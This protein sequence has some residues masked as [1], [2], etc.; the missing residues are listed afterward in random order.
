M[1]APH[2]QCAL[3]RCSQPFVRTKVIVSRITAD[4]FLEGNSRKV[5]RPKLVCGVG[6]HFAAPWT[7]SFNVSHVHSQI[8]RPS[9]TAPPT[10]HTLPRSMIAVS[11]VNRAAKLSDTPLHMTLMTC[12]VPA[13][14]HLCIRTQVHHRLRTVTVH[15]LWSM[16]PKHRFLTQS[17][18][19]LLLWGLQPHHQHWAT[20]RWTERCSARS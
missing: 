5:E 3:V 18:R 13:R 14:K 20:P 6:T 4:I 8:S 15:A 9:T 11:S 16:P 12:I 7:W 1:S 2:H 17:R 19:R 10:G